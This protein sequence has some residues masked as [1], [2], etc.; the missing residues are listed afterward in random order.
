MQNIEQPSICLVTP[1]Y[2]HSD[3]VGDT[4]ESV[5]S[6][7]Y[8]NL[9]YIVV[10]D[11]STDE[12]EE[13][14][15]RYGHQ[16]HHWETWP[17]YRPGPA[18]AINRGFSFSSAEIMGWLNSDDLLMPK[19]LFVVAEVFAQ[20]PQ[21]DWITGVATTIDLKGRYIRS[22]QYRKNSY[23]YLIGDWPVIQQESTFW[24]RNLWDAAGAALDEGCSFAFDSEL[25]CR[26][27]LH[28]EHYHLECPVG[29]YRKV[30]YSTSIKRAAE[31]ARVTESKLQYFRKSAPANVV[32][33][34]A[35]YRIF[36]WLLRMFGSPVL[37]PWIG[38]LFGVADFKYR[39]IIYEPSSGKWRIEL[40]W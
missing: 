39:S 21:V 6:Q 40:R 25:W 17:G 26:F 2:N 9:E 12:S 14:I 13:V 11:G 8:P 18:P 5:V 20:F 31:Y 34:R 4:I 22:R 36:K 27:F 19:S 10:N 15:R 24:R 1:C 33:R 30:P 32:Q 29:A 37:I 16:L 23:D 3:F 35:H 7:G 28:A 38:S